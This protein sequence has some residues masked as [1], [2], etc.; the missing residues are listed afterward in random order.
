MQFQLFPKDDFT[1]AQVNGLVS[2]AAWE[3]LLRELG[4]A[5]QGA[6]TDRLIL[7]LAG[8]VGWL[9]VPERQAVGALMAVHLGR[10]SKVAGVI[11]AEKIAG[12][13]EAQARRDGLDLRL[14]SSYQ[15]AVTWVTS[16]DAPGSRSE[17][18]SSGP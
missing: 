15:D 5:A 14:F 2:L 7:D 16:V 3:K 11:Q 10:M 4:E 8:L 13:V 1:L 9:G 6:R 12:V 17:T 18:G